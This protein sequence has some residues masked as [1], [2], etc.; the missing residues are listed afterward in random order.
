MHLKIQS[1]K[2]KHIADVQFVITNEIAK[3][4]KYREWKEEQIKDRNEE[5]ANRICK[6]ITA[7]LKRTRDYDTKAPTFE[8]EAGVYDMSDDVTPMEGEKPTLIRF[9][10]KEY[11]ITKWKDVLPIVCEILYDF[12]RE[13]FVEI[14]RYINLRRKKWK[15]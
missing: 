7:P 2:L 1:I 5:I 11:P 9:D 12:D 10:D 4:D 8:F 14:T 6:A 15:V 13:K 3:N